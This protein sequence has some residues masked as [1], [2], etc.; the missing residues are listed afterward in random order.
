MAS[1]SFMELETAG[2]DMTIT[3]PKGDSYKGL[4]CDPKINRET[5]PEGYYAYDIRHD[6]DGCGIFCQLCHDV[7]YVNSAGSF[8]TKTPIPE[9]SEPES[10]VFFKIDPEEWAE[11]HE[12]D[13]E[14]DEGFDE[15][16]PENSED[17]W[18]YT[19]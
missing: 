5:L 18:D 8:V 1:I 6:D 11:A 7:V 2:Q 16:C 15:P 9:L 14:S 12:Y 10:F 4:Y 19:F 17:D 13:E 3:S